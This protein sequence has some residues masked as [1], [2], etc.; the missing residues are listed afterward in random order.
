VTA[1][2]PALQILLPMLASA[3][4]VLLRSPAGAWLCF[5]L[6]TWASFAVSVLLVLATRSGAIL[7]YE[8]GG[9]EPPFGIELRIDALNAF[10]LLIV[11]GMAAV[12]A[13]FARSSVLAEIEQTRVYLFY[14]LVLLCLTGLLGISITGDAFNLFVFLEISSLSSYAIIAMGPNRRALLAAFQYLIMG[15]VGGTFIL[16]GIGL[17]YMLTG[18]LNMADLA[19]RL[20]AMA[21]SRTE[22]AAL[23]FIVVGASIK[24]ALFPLHAWL[25]NAYA[26]AP[27]LVSALLAATATKV[28][29]YVLIRF[30]YT[31]FLPERAFDGL[32]LSELMMALAAIAMIA[33]S[34]VAIFQH[35]VKLLLAW[36]SIAQIGYIV[37]GA[38]LVTTAGLAATTLHLLNHAVAKG[39]LFL[40]LGVIVWK[41][42][43]ARLSDLA[44]LGRTLPWVG[45]AFVIGALSLI[46]VPFTGGFITKWYLLV[47][48]AEQELWLL[49]GAV[50]LSSLLS[51]IY[52]GRVIETLYF[53]APSQ[54]TTRSEPVP[55]LM[56]S[57]VWLLALLNVAI[58]S[59]S[60]PFAAIAR[61]AAG[62]LLGGTP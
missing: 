2:L 61:T 62:Q 4:C 34:V 51:I 35:N 49:A 16:I 42:G 39:C 36:S 57:S 17:M 11:S 15:T 47:A 6:A 18:T 60:E 37:L 5:T 20:P 1:Q 29:A 50:V 41:T 53:R 22:K 56:L 21:D 45:A 43:G 19:E 40:A 38:A 46:G 44:G 9:W 58:G 52:M 59:Y 13:P 23:G 32:M 31:V 8:M 14:A 54:G 10:V 30:I 28:A 7:S 26:Y 33:G 3:L 12:M 27:S 55:V 24:L 25:P 48:V